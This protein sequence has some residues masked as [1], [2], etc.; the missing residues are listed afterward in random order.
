M[1]RL[2]D[3]GLVERA[4]F[5]LP[6][7]MGTPVDSNRTLR[8]HLR[9]K[10]YGPSLLHSGLMFSSNLEGDARFSGRARLTTM[11]LNARGA[12]WRQD[13]RLGTRSAAASEW[14]Q[15]ID[16]SRCWFVAPKLEYRNDYEDVFTAGGIARYRFQEARAQVEAGRQLA[17]VGELRTGL[18]FGWGRSE[19]KTPAGR[20]L[21]Q[22]EGRLGGW[23]TRAAYDL[24]DDPDAPRSGSGAV[25][26]A[27]LDRHGLGSEFG[28]DR[29]TGEWVGFATW[30]DNT[31]FVELETGS[32]LGSQL[33]LQALFRIGGLHSFSGFET[34]EL[35]GEA[36][37][38]LRAGFSRPLTGDI[39]LVGTRVHVA[40]WFE[41]GNAWVSTG[42]AD[43]D[44]LRYAGTL[45]LWANT[46]LGPLHLAQ[47]WADGGHAM[48]YVSLGQQFGLSP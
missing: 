44:E 20:R 28:F 39:D 32:S 11:E 33:P 17:Y 5:D 7:A 15:P 23:T 36:F 3:L 41:L 9:E 47:G 35:T 42:A 1:N 12:E 37:G 4:D 25:L 29:I 26:Q 2:Y 31:G 14:Y 6:F 10:T 46:L 13:F 18:Y 40:A 16:W 27:T 48:L 24:V 34:G 45:S 8:V 30:R 38:V 21:P 43:L 22:Q 19:L